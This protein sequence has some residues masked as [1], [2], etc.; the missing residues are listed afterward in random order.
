MNR[1]FI[2]LIDLCAGSLGEAL[3]PQ[4]GFGGFPPNPGFC[5]G[6]THAKS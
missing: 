1:A 3:V 4:W 5:K 6:S 2:T